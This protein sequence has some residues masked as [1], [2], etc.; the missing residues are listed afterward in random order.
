MGTK[1]D[2]VVIH[3]EVHGNSAELYKGLKQ[4]TAGLEIALRLLARSEY[5]GAF[6]GDMQKINAILG[7]ETARSQSVSMATSI[8]SATIKISN[9]TSGDIPHV[10]DRISEKE[11][12]KNGQTLKVQTAVSVPQGLKDDDGFEDGWTGVPSSATA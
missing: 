5:A 12:S 9:Q 7:D 1:K 11:D 8:E 4:K 3:C 10:Q 6:F 2:K